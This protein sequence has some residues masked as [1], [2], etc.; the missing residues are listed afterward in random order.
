MTRIVF[1]GGNVFDGHRH[2]G[3][4]AVLVEDGRVVAVGEVDRDAAGRRRRGGRRRRRAGRAGV[5]RRPRPRRPGR[6]RAD[7][8]ATSPR[9]TPGTAYLATVAAYAADHPE[10]R[11]SLG[12]GWAMAAFPGGTP[13]AAD[14]DAVVPD[15][16]V[17]LP[18][19]DH[20]GAWVNSRALEL[21]GIDRHTPDPPTAGSSA[22]PTAA[23]PA[24]CTRARWSW[25]PGCAPADDRRRVR[26]GAA[27]RA[28][29]PALAR[30]HRLAGRDR[31]GVRRHGRPRP[32]LPG[33]AAGDGDLTGVGRRR[34]V[35]GARPRR[36][37]GRRPGRAAR[38]LQPR[39]VPGHERQDHAGRRRREL[40]R[41]DDGALPRPL[42][43]PDRPTAG[44]PS[45]TRGA[46]REAVP[47]LVA[48]GF[49]VHVHAIGDRGVARG[50]RRVRRRVPP[51]G[52]APPRRAPAGRPPRRRAALRRRS[53]SP[54]TCRRCGPA[55][56]TRWSS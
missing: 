2:R 53:G 14:L 41:G 32:D 35:V 4:A 46:L 19:R 47:A 25:S 21:A 29:L 30:R 36:R 12:G 17:F 16:P 9:S 34:A 10:R 42:R 22:T 1:T 26:R 33:G 54:P 40:H 13:T 24:P 27:R 3:P 23:P 51:A 31:R 45:S 48:E 6:S 5:R 43:P 18:N 15:R 38:A 49:Q 37:A 52:P 7:R 11:G 28:A 55:S 8:G 39:P 56:T 44:T 20:H 50:A